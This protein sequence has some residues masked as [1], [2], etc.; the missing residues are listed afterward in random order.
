MLFYNSRGV[1]HTSLLH[2]M[3]CPKYAHTKNY[4]RF[5]FTPCHYAAA[6]MTNVPVIAAARRPAVLLNIAPAINP[7]TNGVA[8]SGIE[9]QLSSPLQISPPRPTNENTKRGG[10]GRTH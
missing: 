9:V 1:S 7:D 3:L 4:M 6:P 5:R 2:S 8:F 10:V